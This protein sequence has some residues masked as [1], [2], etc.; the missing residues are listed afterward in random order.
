MTARN[1][2]ERWVSSKKKEEHCAPPFLIYQIALN[3]SGFS[4]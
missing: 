2:L 1:A 4:C 3:I